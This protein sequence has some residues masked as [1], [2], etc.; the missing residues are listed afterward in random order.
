LLQ[1]NIQSFLI[2]WLILAPFEHFMDNFSI[3]YPLKV[4]ELG[5]YGCFGLIPLPHTESKGSETPR[6]LNQRRRHQHHHVDSVDM[7]S[8]LA[9]TGN[10]TWYQLSHRRM[11]KNLNKSVNSSM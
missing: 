11:L 9:L 3:P 5:M 2:L 10:E 1:V 6:Q 7:E 4:P 8:H